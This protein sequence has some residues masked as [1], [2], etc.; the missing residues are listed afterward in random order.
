MANLIVRTVV[1]N[2]SLTGS[3]VVGGWLAKIASAAV[4]VD[5][6]MITP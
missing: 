3:F 5:V 1:R 6:W 2:L 4:G